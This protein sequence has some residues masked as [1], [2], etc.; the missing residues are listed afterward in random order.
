MKIK[1]G[2]FYNKAENETIFRANVR[3]YSDNCVDDANVGQ[4]D[5]DVDGDVS[6]LHQ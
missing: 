2:F 6:P 5:A 4:A 1:L 3:G